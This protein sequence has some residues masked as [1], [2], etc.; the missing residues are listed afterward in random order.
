[1]VMMVI[2]VLVV[3]A[4]VLVVMFAMLVMA[5]AFDLGRSPEAAASGLGG[6]D[7]HAGESYGVE[8]RERGRAI[9]NEV[10]ER[11]GHHVARCA[12]SAVKVEGGHEREAFGFRM[13]SSAVDCRRWLIFEARTAAPKP[14]SML[15]T[16]TPAAQELIIASSA[17]SPSNAAP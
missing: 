3:M 10:E 12:G 16:L 8:A 5:A 7:A 9:G 15:T 2:A 13:L 17:A 6:G 11:G 4:L 1:M 14:L